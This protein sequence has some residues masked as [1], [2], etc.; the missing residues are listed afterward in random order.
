MKHYKRILIAL[1]IIPSALSICGQEVLS[2]EDCRTLAI[3]NNKKLSVA[4]MNMEIATDERGAARTK[5]LPKVDAVAGWELLSK[6]VSILNKDQKNALNHLGTNATSQLGSELSS[7]IQGMAMQGLITP[8]AAANLGQ[9]LGQLNTMIAGM[10]DNLGKTIRQAFRTNNRNMFGGAVMV[11]QPI[12]MGG[13]LTALNRIADINEDMM[14]NTYDMTLQN[15]LYEIEVNYWL[16]VSLRQKERLAES[17][18]KLVTRLNDDVHKMID[19]GIATRADGLNVEV[20][21]HE[22]EMTKMKVS[23]NL[24][25]AKMLL[26]QLCGLDMNKPITLADEDKDSFSISREAPL[27]NPVR[28]ELRM[29]DNAIDI[30]EQSSKLVTALYYR[31]QVALTGGYMISNPNVYNGF[32]RKFSGIWN[33]GLLVR[34]PIWNWNEGR[35]KLHATKAATNI[36]KLER[37]DLGEK[38]NLQVKQCRFKVAEAEKRLNMSEKHVASAEENLRCATVGFR[39]GVMSLTEV[40]A[41]QTAWQSAHS[42][43]I[44]SEI[45][46]Q[47]SRVSLLKA[48]GQL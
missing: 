8:E 31:P 33:I 22:A 30:S 32:E 29:I 7:T 9:Q 24:T 15:T 16:V 1:L 21:V 44:D 38:I 19:E 12:Y 5:Y 3:K 20:R 25:L 14:S 46:V 26:C 41:A 34:M 35:Y 17:Y 4:R 48:L 2:L 45:E 13:S 36:A 39:E 43:R 23:D 10:G 42:M 11:R 40:M 18:Y 28:P 27:D 47:L 37:E 6:E